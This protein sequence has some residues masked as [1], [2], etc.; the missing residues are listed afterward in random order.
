MLATLGGAA[1]I[2]RLDVAVDR[3]RSSKGMIRV[4]LTADPA[5][6]PACVDDAD[7]VTR[8]VPAS[9]RTVHFTGLPY[10][11]YAVA[12]IHD[13]NGNSR[14]DTFA[15]IPREG[16]GFSRNPV[17]RFGPPRFSAARFQLAS[18]AETQQVNM[19]YIF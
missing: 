15:G 11:G 5:N 6:F 8:S 9:T 3:M 14:L 16:F 13:E 7:A 17:V 19:R 12:V 4:C 1:P 10:G 18:D 2:G